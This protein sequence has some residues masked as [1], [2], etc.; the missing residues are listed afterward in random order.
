MIRN[1]VYWR[2]TTEFLFGMQPLA[3][4]LSLYLIKHTPCLQDFSSPMP[5]VLCPFKRCQLSESHTAF[6]FGLGKCCYALF[7]YLQLYHIWTFLEQSGKPKQTL[8]YIKAP[9]HIRLFVDEP[10]LYRA[11]Q[12]RPADNT[13]QIMEVSCA[14]HWRGHNSPPFIVRI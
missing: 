10:L 3:S 13:Q 12:T 14:L 1:H 11:I 7:L 9:P 5:A 4:V 2:S 8:L 6:N